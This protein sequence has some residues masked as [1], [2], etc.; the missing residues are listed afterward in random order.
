MAALEIL[1]DANSIRTRFP[2][3][4]EVDGAAIGFAIEEAA[5][6]VDDTWVEADRLLAVSMLTAHILSV[7]SAS[8]GTDGRDVVSE[9]IGPISVTYAQV[10]AASV[11]AKSNTQTTSYGKRYGQLLKRNFGGI[12]VI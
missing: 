7:A 6:S 8:S 1:P 4:A 11:T 2:E 10:A 5:R 3:F 12:I 9:T